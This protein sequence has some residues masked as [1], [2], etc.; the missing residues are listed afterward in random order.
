M[1]DESRVG[2]CECVCMY[3]VCVRGRERK[4][5]RKKERGRADVEA[6][7]ASAKVG[8]SPPLAYMY[9]SP[10]WPSTDLVLSY[11]TWH[12]A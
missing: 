2:G 10:T 3:V 6:T 1:E 5:E 9:L 4:R 12:T 7:A 11:V 8:T